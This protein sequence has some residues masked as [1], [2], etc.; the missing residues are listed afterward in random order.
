MLLQKKYRDS[1]KTVIE[2]QGVNPNI[3]KHLK[4]I[5]EHIGGNINEI[6]GSTGKDSDFPQKGNQGDTYSY[7][8]R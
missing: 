3:R 5:Y 8:V 6:Q 7:R 1:L 4:V 2:S